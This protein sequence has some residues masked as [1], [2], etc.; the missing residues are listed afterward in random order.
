MKQNMGTADRLLRAVLVAP[1]AVVL[2]AL[3]GWT[4]GWAVLALVV[5]AVML[6]TAAVGSCPLYL[7]FGIST[8]T[9]RRPHHREAHV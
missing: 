9:P 1:V 7:P 3:A 8:R 2:A 5:A 4:T 6:L